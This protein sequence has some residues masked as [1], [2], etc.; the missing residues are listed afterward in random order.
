MPTTDQPGFRNTMD[1]HF[2]GALLQDDFVLQTAAHLSG[3]GFSSDNTLAGVAVCRDGYPIVQ[4]IDQPMD[5]LNI[6]KTI[7]P[8]HSVQVPIASQTSWLMR[9]L[10][11]PDGPLPESSTPPRA[12]S[13]RKADADTS[14]EPIRQR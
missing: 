5:V 12:T 8:T 7:A 6:V 9:V 10:S 11:A 1:R 2:P 14:S 4:T 3:L 13:I